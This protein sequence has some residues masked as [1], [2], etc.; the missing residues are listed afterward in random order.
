VLLSER[1]LPVAVIPRKPA[2]TDAAERELRDSEAICWTPIF[3]VARNA[4][5]GC[6]YVVLDGFRRVREMQRRGGTHILAVVG[7][8]SAPLLQ[9]F[10]SL[11]L[12]ITERT[13]QTWSLPKLGR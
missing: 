4:P 9:Q 8:T 3:T 12:P 1:I 10:A 6:R 13:R 7:V 11:G 2:V 5:E